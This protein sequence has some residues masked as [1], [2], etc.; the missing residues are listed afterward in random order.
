MNNLHE[1][2]RDRLR[3][4]AL[5]NG[6]DSLADHEILELMLSFAV[7]YK[8]MNSIA[9]QLINEFGSIQNVL[10]RPTKELE[11]IIGV[12]KK[13]AQ[14]LN[15][16]S[17]FCKY[18]HVFDVKEK[19]NYISSAFQSYQ[20]CKKL[21][22]RLDHEEFYAVCIDN[23]NCVKN[24]KKFSK[25]TNNETGVNLKELVQYTLN[26]NC[27]NVIICHNHPKGC[28]KPSANDL[29]ITKNIYMALAFHGISLLDHIIIG[30]Q[31]KYYSFSSA[32]I[33]ESWKNS[34]D[35]FLGR[36]QKDLLKTKRVIYDY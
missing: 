2:H 25:G 10:T 1:G 34:V 17:L 8:D 24:F 36:E 26:S 28:E 3:Q 32:Q 31:G 27:N 7:P 9:H 19:K 21:V 4:K 18:Y 6:I 12:G 23:D 15:C 16:L 33:F 22:E 20:F 30:E 29:N 13:T 5:E 35:Q 11:K 14:Y